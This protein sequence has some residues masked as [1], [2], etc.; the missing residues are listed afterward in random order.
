MEKEKDLVA[1]LFTESLAC[2]RLLTVSLVYMRGQAVDNLQRT[3]ILPPL[4][5]P[6]FPYVN[7]SQRE[8]T[9]FMDIILYP[10]SAAPTKENEKI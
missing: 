6:C 3:R 10:S 9:A 5:L 2:P 1:E 8:V 4:A 7:M